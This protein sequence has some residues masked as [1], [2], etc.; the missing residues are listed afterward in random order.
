MVYD[1]ASLHY[2][3]PLPAAFRAHPAVDEPLMGRVTGCFSRCDN[4]VINLPL[5]SP[6]LVVL[7]AGLTIVGSCSQHQPCK[8]N[9]LVV[10]PS[11][12]WMSCVD[13]LP[14]TVCITQRFHRTCPWESSCFRRYLL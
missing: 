5:G 6:L 10:L 12:W 4:V 1:M 8:N 7:E 3:I 9:I 2:V 11:G 14:S 13:G